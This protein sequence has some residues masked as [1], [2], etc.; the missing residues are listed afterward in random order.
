MKTTIRIFML[1]AAIAVGFNL[2]QINW[3]TPLEGKSAVAV[4]GVMAAS[5]AFLLLALL[6]LS[7]KIE[8]QKK[9]R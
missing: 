6:A 5:C 7:K 9:K 3:E 1:L 4:I 8:V 2:F